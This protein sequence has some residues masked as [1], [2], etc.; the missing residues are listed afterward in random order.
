[1]TQEELAELADKRIS[2]SMKIRSDL[3]HKYEGIVNLLETTYNSEKINILQ[4]TNTIVDNRLL[5]GTITLTVTQTKN[6]SHW[7]LV[8]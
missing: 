5:I 7:R 2:F 8:K 3:Y 1:M 4:L 6:L